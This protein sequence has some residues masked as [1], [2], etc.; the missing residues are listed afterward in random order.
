[1]SS[2]IRQETAVFL[3]SVLHGA[4]LSI[5]YDLLRALRRS[6]RHSLVALSLEDFFYWL[7]AG[8]LTFHLVFW[9]LGGVI[10]GY[11]FVGMLIGFLLYH[12]TLSRGFV[13]AVS[14][15]LRWIGR[16]RKRIVLLFH[17]KF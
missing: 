8:I 13:R 3:C 5:L 17:K 10:R 4:A 11:A 14:T 15:L 6:I 16:V 7:L 12:I 9:E 1:M 2:V